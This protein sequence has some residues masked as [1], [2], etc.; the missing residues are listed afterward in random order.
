MQPTW[1]LVRRVVL[2]MFIGWLAAQASDVRPS[3]PVSLGFSQR[4]V[5]AVMVDGR[6]PETVY[7]A[8]AHDKDFGGVFVS[9]DSGAHW[10]QISLG[11]G[12]EDVLAL[13]QDNTGQLYAGT[14]RGLFRYYNQKK[15]WVRIF[16]MRRSQSFEVAAMD[17][18]GGSWVLAGAQGMAHSSNRGRSWVQQTVEGE[19]QFLAVETGNTVM[20]AATPDVL[21]ASNDGGRKWDSLELPA[22]SQ[23]RSVALDNNQQIW[24]ASPQGV[25]YRDEVGN[26]EKAEGVPEAP[27]VL[28]WDSA[29][30]RMLAVIHSSIIL[31]SADGE[32]WER[33][34]ATNSPVQ[35]LVATR[36]RLFVGTEQDGMLGLERQNSG[37]VSAKL[38]KRSNGN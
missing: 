15:F 25:F 31:E 37:D 11:L 7:A 10:S 36:Q 27:S 30:R 22:V 33:L 24:L 6:N 14:K 23:I 20:V 28:T 16:P 26:W 19:Q 13:S 4:C 5:S 32:H 38:G 9:R 1:G 21:L 2:L 3:G 29:G 17:V 8:V 34:M 18:S 35:A 12:G